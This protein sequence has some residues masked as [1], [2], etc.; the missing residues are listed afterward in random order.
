MSN[1]HASSPPTTTPT[2]HFSTSAWGPQ[3]VQEATGH[4]SLWLTIITTVFPEAR[5]TLSSGKRPSVIPWEGRAGPLASPI[6]HP[7][8]QTLANESLAKADIQRGAAAAEP[9][10]PSPSACM[11]LLLSKTSSHYPAAQ[12]GCRKDARNHVPSESIP[13]LSPSTWLPLHSSKIPSLRQC[14]GAHSHRCPEMSGAASG[15]PSASQCHGDV[16][17]GHTL[18]ML[19]GLMIGKITSPF[20]CLVS[21]RSSFCSS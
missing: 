19:P 1:F 6:A 7:H 9:A 12:Q 20:L 5:A 16:S 2:H 17:P 11:H 4:L 3:L 14:F 10:K 8:L 18:P 15:T 21:R 13:P